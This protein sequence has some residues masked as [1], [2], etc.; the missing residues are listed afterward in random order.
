MTRAEQWICS[1]WLLCPIIQEPQELCNCHTHIQRPIQAAEQV[2]LL[3]GEDA[4]I[5]QLLWVIENLQ[6]ELHISNRAFGLAEI[7]LKESQAIV[8]QLQVS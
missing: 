5:K 2:W 4:E 3:A 6:E 7:Q 8:D 1:C